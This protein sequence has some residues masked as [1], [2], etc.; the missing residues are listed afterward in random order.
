MPDY[1]KEG[2]GRIPRLLE[3]ELA[4]GQRGVP[5]TRLGR[6]RDLGTLAVALHLGLGRAIPA[7]TG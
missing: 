5:I 7:G 4:V 2:G 1:P 3:A 6:E